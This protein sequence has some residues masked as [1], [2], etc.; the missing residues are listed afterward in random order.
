MCGRVRTQTP[1]RLCQLAFCSDLPAAPGLVPRDGDVDESLE[2]VTLVLRCG[3]PRVLEL[4]VRGE[5][6]TGAD[7]L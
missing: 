7:E 1:D 5:V 4:L 2:E 3:A 6:L